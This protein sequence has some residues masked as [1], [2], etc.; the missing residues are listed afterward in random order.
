MLSIDFGLIVIFAI[1]WILVLVLNKVYF[2]PV[3]RI[4]GKRDR[5]IGRDRTA[6]REAM[7]KYEEG[8]ARIE[9]ALKSARLSARE[10]RER[11][12]RE[13][14]KE[15]EAI[16]AEVS[17]ECRTQ[18]E[19]AKKELGEKVEQLKKELEPQGQELAEKIEKRLLH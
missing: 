14:Q 3:L 11:F 1:V 18:V 7:E 12:E 8:V 10:T 16:L 13:A 17:H 15:K 9:G 19:Q 4:M 5:V 2:R 6:A